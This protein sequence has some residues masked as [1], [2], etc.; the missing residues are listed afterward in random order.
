MRLLPAF[1]SD[2]FST[3]R[4][5]WT[6]TIW[7]RL[8]GWPVVA[9]LSCLV[10][11]MLPPGIHNWLSL[12]AMP[13]VMEPAFLTFACSALFLIVICTDGP[14]P[15]MRLGPDW[16]GPTAAYLLFPFIAVA[17]VRWTNLHGWSIPAIAISPLV[18]LE[19]LFALMGSALHAIERR[20][21]VPPAKAPGTYPYQNMGGTGM[22][23]GLVPVR[24]MSWRTVLT[25]RDPVL[26]RKAAQDAKDCD[27]SEIADILDRRA[28]QYD[29]ARL[30][31]DRSGV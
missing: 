3:V 26:L 4:G 30:A 20:Y 11:R 31:A 9:L 5:A 29:N 2:G 18:V 21:P 28:A 23:F 19:I 8:A 17:L 12:S 10:W 24:D 7:A 1:L 15:D 27:A 25:S 16:T 6:E 14:S 13:T 22:G